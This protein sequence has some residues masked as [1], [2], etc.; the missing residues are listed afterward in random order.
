VAEHERRSLVIGHRHAVADP[1]QRLEGN[2]RV[3]A[4]PGL[5]SATLTVMSLLA[6]RRPED[7]WLSR[8]SNQNG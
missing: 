4:P 2:P 8:I 6:G 1:R 7:A 5:R 3:G